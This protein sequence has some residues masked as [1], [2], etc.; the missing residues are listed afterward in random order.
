MTTNLYAL[1]EGRI[2]HANFGKPFYIG[3][4][5]D[6][7][8]HRHL[9][10]AKSKA[11]HRNWRLHEV[12]ASHRAMDAETGIEILATFETKAEACTAEREHIARWGRIGIEPDGI[13]CNLASGG[14]GPDAALMQMPE[15][16]ARNAKAQ[17]ALGKE[18]LSERGQRGGNSA[19]SNP[20]NKA[21]KSAAST[22]MNNLTWA[23]PVIRA[24]RIAAMKGKKKTRSQA[25]DDARRANAKKAQ[26]DE[27][28]Q[29]RSEELRR[30]WADP[31]YKARLAEQKRKAWEDPEKRARMLDARGTGGKKAAAVDPVERDS[32][33]SGDP[34]R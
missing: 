16:R 31:A 18:V 34:C 25:S 21:I 9:R 10:E 28:K 22:A 32:E 4:G 30:R 6:K 19:S 14:Q 1:I 29:K 20:A 3:I 5:T 13:L 8:P 17:L 26:S 11:G 7:R 12:L 2:G 23:D 24:R 27:A 15:I 33:H